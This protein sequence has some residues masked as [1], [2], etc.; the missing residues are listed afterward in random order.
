[1]V[2]GLIILFLLIS[3]FAIISGKKTLLRLFLG[4]WSGILF[5]SE[6][7]LFGMQPYG[8]S[9]GLCIT[10]G[11]CS[12]LLGY[13]LKNT[14]LCAPTIRIGNFRWTETA[15]IINY[16]AIRVMSILTTFFYAVVTIRV[17]GVLLSGTSYL[18]LRNMYG[19]ENS[20]LSPIESWL[21][22]WIFAPM[23]FIFIPLLALIIT[24]KQKDYI[25]IIL[26]GISLGLYVLCT[27]SR[28]IVLLLIVCFILSLGCTGY[29][30]DKN[31][32]K[33]LVNKYRRYII[34]LAIIIVVISFFRYGASDKGVT[35]DTMLES[36]YAYFTTT[37]PLLDYWIDYTNTTGFKSYGMA[38]MSGFVTIIFMI[39]HRFGFQYPTL[40]KQ[41]N[42]YIALTQNFI[43]TFSGHKYNAFVSLFYYF[44]VDFRWAGVVIGSLIFGIMTAR[45]ERKVSL[46]STDYL[47]A[48]YMLYSFAIVKSFTRLEFYNTTYLVSFLML[49]LCFKKDIVDRGEE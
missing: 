8:D 40:L 42:E 33:K 47:I 41:T 1:M 14:K 2:E 4:L 25:S 46:Y 11:C 37:V 49:L 43:Q 6:L 28:I 34:V 48:K 39:L 36:Y 31:R 10:V 7:K 21:N 29:K 16:R 27:G 23:I 45:I 20:Y 3:S 30:I 15:S 12:F 19:G 22:G 13:L 9:A 5:A 26:M 38:A 24:K 17:I 18:A 44:Y 32:M 35:K